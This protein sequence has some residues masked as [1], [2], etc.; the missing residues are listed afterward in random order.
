MPKSACRQEP[1]HGCPLRGSNSISLRQVQTLTANHCTEFRDPNGR[2]RGSTEGAEG[3]CNSIGRKIL[4]NGTSQD[5]PGTNPPPKSIH[6]RVHGSCYIY[7]R[8]LSYLASVGGD[9]LGPVEPWCP[10]KGE[11]EKDESV[12]SGYLGRERKDPL[13]GKGKGNVVGRPRKR[14]TFEIKQ[15][16]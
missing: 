8:G 14:T 13:R 16:K 4:T 1:Q 10:I 7:S 9:A 3:A 15:S 2:A 12:T 11:C 6:G 5:F